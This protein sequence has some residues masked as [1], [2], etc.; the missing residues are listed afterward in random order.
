MNHDGHNVNNYNNARNYYTEKA[1]YT[2]NI[3]AH[4]S[5]MH[6]QPLTRLPSLN[7]FARDLNQEVSQN[8][9]S[10]SQ[11]NYGYQPNYVSVNRGNSYYPDLNNW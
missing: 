10:P 4:D 11:I 2:N 5:Y 9:S 3:K 8:W 6:I 7:T 1:P